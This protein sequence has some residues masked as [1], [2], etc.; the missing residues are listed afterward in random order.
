MASCR[1][2][3]VS[4]GRYVSGLDKLRGGVPNTNWGAKEMFRSLELPD[5]TTRTNLLFSVVLNEIGSW[6]LRKKQ[7]QLYAALV[8][9]KPDL[10][11]VH[12]EAIILPNWTVAPSLGLLVACC[13]LEE[14]T[15][16][17]Y[18]CSKPPSPEPSKYTVSP[19]SLPSFPE[20]L[21]GF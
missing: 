14:E 21:C 8:I 1:F 17:P 7:Q 11:T 2:T 5:D 3:K 18:M 13:T 4:V 15:I 10:M 16:Q 19:L 9:S 20:T 6:I 12:Y